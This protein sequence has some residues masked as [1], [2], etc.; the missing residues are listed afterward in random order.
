LLYTVCIGSFSGI[1]DRHFDGPLLL[2]SRSSDFHH[3]ER[4]ISLLDVTTNS[5]P[6]FGRFQGNYFGSGIDWF[7]PEV[8]D[9]RFWM[10][11]LVSAKMTFQRVAKL[12]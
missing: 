1:G 7:T 6:I 2:E 5:H 11:H 3:L 8:A 4:L 10:D 9:M 12:L